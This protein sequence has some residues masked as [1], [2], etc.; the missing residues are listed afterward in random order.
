MTITPSVGP[1]D[2]VAGL[3]GSLREVALLWREVARVA[4]PAG[5]S[6]LGVLHVVEQQRAMRVSDLAI[7]RH[8]GVSTMSRQV[9]ELTAAGLLEWE[10]S[11]DDARSH[12]VR[13][14]PAGR[15]NLD[16]ART[17][18][19]DRLLPALQGWTDTELTEL[20]RQLTRLTHDLTAA[21]GRAPEGD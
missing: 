19:L 3:L 11:A 4:F 18:L 16:R 7:C 1:R 5:S 12:V 10:L 15:A 6:G 8:V 9:A 14:T 13:L 2:R 20:E 17:G 21:T